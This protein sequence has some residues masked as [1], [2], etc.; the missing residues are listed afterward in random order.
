MA[1]KLK[2]PSFSV[3][4]AVHGQ[5]E[6]KHLEDVLSAAGFGYFGEEDIHWPREWICE[7]C[8]MEVRDHAADGT[9]PV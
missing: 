3:S 4:V 5:Q 8:G 7:E 9:C 1:T 6:L 2:N